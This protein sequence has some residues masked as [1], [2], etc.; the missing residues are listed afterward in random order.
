MSSRRSRSGGSF[1]ENALIRKLKLAAKPP[2]PDLSV[3]IF[4]CCRNQ[5]KP[6]RPPDAISCSC[7][8]RQ[9]NLL[10]VEIQLV[11]ASRNSV[12]NS[13]T[14]RHSTPS[15]RCLDPREQLSRLEYRAAQF[16]KRQVTHGGELVNQS[17]VYFFSCAALSLQQHGNVGPGNFPNHGVDRE[18]SFR[19]AID[20][21]SIVTSS[22]ARLTSVAIGFPMLIHATA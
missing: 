9:Q 13:P 21:A 11:D 5:P 14:A 17:P 6:M 22:N 19:L 3:N 1:D 15:E 12:P 18:D 2:E 16:H 20:K 7:S 8:I 10:T 4:A